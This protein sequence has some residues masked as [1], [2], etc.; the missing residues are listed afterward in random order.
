MC[1][2]FA[3]VKE[4]GVERFVRAYADAGFVVQVHDHWNF[5]ASDGVPRHDIDPAL[6]LATRGVP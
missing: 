4:H 5:G 1:H 3:A 6:Q 2:D